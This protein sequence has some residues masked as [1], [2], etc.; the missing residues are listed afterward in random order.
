[1]K[2]AVHTEPLFRLNAGCLCL[3]F[4][5]N[6]TKN[7]VRTFADLV[8]WSQVAEVIGPDEARRLLAGALERPREASS[9]LR[10]AQSLAET[11][12]RLFSSGVARRAADSL[13]LDR[14]NKELGGALPRSRIVP[15]A[16]G[17]SWAW[18]SQGQDLESV[19]WP[20]AVSA[21]QIL[22]E[23]LSVVRECAGRDCHWLF[24]DM[25]KNQSR[26]W[27]D[28]RLCGN[29]EKARRHYQRTKAAETAA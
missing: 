22:T 17:F 1:M 13:D 2:A 19:L 3:D 15:S 20:V 12:Y 11:M 7:N 6:V 5:N 23:N 9:V 29:R 14:L 16:Q 8:Q 25:S 21:S 27:C 4:A 18:G 28:M 24:I 26:Q 10:R